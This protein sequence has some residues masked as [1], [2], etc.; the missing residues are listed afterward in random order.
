[1]TKTK[2]NLTKSVITRVICTASAIAMCF[3]LASCSAN[4]ESSNGAASSEAN[5]AGMSVLSGVK[6][7]GALG[8]QPK[9][10]LTAPIDVKPNSYAILQDGNGTKI[11]ENSRVC[12]NGIVYLSLIHISEPTRRTERSRMPSSA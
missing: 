5:A 11:P 9:V 2:L 4:S 7:S 8:K 3:G 10:E 12:A 1:M 6:A